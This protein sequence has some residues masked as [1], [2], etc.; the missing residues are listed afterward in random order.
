MIGQFFAQ[1]GDLLGGDW[2]SA[3]PPFTPFVCQYIG[4]FLVGQCFVPWLHDRCAEFLAFDG[5][6]TLQTL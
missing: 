4:N 2:A 6:W 1:R 5:D 3:V